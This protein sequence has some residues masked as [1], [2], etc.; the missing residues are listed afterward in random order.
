MTEPARFKP[1]R[2]G[3]V[4]LYQYDEQTF[5]F[6]DG[7]IALRGRNTSGK[8]KALELLIPFVL[9]GDIRPHKLDPFGKGDKTMAWNLTGCADDMSTRVGYVWM[10]HERVDEHGDTKRVTVGI[11]M[12]G[13][14]GTNDVRRW[15]W[16]LEGA[17]IGED[18]HLIKH[19][20]Q[21]RYALPRDEFKRALEERH[22]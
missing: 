22:G 12:K 10:E 13:V 14:R 20:P 4:G 17:R 11:G 21:G 5:P 1:T 15:Y 18:L 8:S 19:T 7:R 3:I 2:A 6:G 16:I 9:D